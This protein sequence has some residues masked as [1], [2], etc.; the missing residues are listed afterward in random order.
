M[1]N[2]IV[3]ISQGIFA[4]FDLKNKSIY[5]FE[6]CCQYSSSQA[7]LSGWSFFELYRVVETNT[8]S[9][10]DKDFP[11]C[12]SDT[13]TKNYP[14]NRGSKSMKQVEGYQSS[15]DSEETVD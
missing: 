10:R 2:Y 4:L 12:S 8:F 5:L 9:G 14:D 3:D 15:E 1:N 7:L 6:Q 11:E 13:R